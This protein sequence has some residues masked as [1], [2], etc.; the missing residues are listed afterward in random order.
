MPT[1][2]DNIFLQ[3]ASMSHTFLGRQAKEPVFKK[4]DKEVIGGMTSHSFSAP[5]KRGQQSKGIISLMTLIKEDLQIDIDKAIKIEDES[6]AEY[7]EIKTQTDKEKKDLKDKIDDLKD[8]RTTLEGKREDEETWKG[9]EE[10]KLH[11]S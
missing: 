5:S 9:E 2:D 6:E 7:Q 8:E 1:K 4:T 10:E 3:E 11:N